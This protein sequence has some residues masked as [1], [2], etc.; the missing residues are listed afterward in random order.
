MYTVT[1]QQIKDE[2]QE[3]RRAALEPPTVVANATVIAR[4]RVELPGYPDALLVVNPLLKDGDVWLVNST[5]TC[6]LPAVS[7]E[8]RVVPSGYVHVVGTTEVGPRYASAITFQCGLRATS[9]NTT[10]NFPPQATRCP[11]CVAAVGEQ[12]S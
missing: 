7:T 4:L 11:V 1:A 2:I 6:R 3:I 10:V 12:P 5:L 9:A 8:L